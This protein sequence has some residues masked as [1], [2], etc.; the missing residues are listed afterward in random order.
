MTAKTEQHLCQEFQD[1]FGIQYS[2]VQEILVVWIMMGVSHSL[3][4]NTTVFNTGGTHAWKEVQSQY[5]LHGL[6]AI[7][8]SNVDFYLGDAPSSLAILKTGLADI[9]TFC[10]KDME[11]Y[12]AGH[13][14]YM[15]HGVDI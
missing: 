4:H 2:C 12:G 9:A 10:E 14:R 13:P 6:R 7:F 1:L 15:S 5:E 3:S 11:H 8:C